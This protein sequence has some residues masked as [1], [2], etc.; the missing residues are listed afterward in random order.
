MINLKFLLV[1]GFVVF[2]VVLGIAGAAS[3]WYQY[4]VGGFKL[5]EFLS[6]FKLSYSGS[7]ST[8]NFFENTSNS[9]SQ[10]VS[11]NFKTMYGLIITCAAITVILLAIEAIILFT[12][13]FDFC[14]RLS[15][16]GKLRIPLIVLS[17]LSTITSLIAWLLLFWHPEAMKTSSTGSLDFVSDNSNPSAGW[18]IYLILSV[19]CLV[20][21]V[22]LGL[23]GTPDHSGYRFFK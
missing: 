1:L 7:S 9:C 15:F 21:T 8:C 2:L 13:A 5:E 14:S 4:E 17:L 18:A 22:V 6:Y 19:F 20:T 12:W 3:P 23:S 10:F 11:D 16:R